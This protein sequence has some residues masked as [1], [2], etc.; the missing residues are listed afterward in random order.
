MSTTHV[1]VPARAW[2]GN[3]VVER[4]RRVAIA[5][6]KQCGRAVVPN[7]SAVTPL[8]DVL[9]SLPDAPRFMCVEP[10]LAADAVETLGGSQPRPRTALVLIGPEGG[11]S[12]AEVEQARRLAPD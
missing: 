5:S 11:W 10:G 4:W 1:A 12:A 6:T 7:V 2:K 9:K 8:A 3:A